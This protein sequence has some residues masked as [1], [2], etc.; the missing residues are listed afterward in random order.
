MHLLVNNNQGTDAMTSHPRDEF[1]VEIRVAIPP[2]L[3]QQDVDALIAAERKRGRELREAGAIER[4]WRIP[5]TRDNVGIWRA[6]SATDLHGLLSSLPLFPYMA[7]TVRPLA[8][9]PL[10]AGDNSFPS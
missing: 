5:G 7:I 6:E 8:Q 1:L 10:E 9:H 4:I 3:A 2:T